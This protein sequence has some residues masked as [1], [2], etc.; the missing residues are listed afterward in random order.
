M[1]KNKKLL[2]F[3]V[4]GLTLFGVQVFAKAG[5]VPSKPAEK[6]DLD[7]N[8]NAKLCNE[9]QLIQLQKLDKIADHLLMEVASEKNLRKFFQDTCANKKNSLTEDKQ[10]KALS[11]MQFKA[12][13]ETTVNMCT[14]YDIMMDSAHFYESSKYSQCN[15]LIS[16]HSGE[17]AQKMKRLDKKD[18]EKICTEAAP[19]Q[20]AF[21]SWTDP[22]VL[23]KIKK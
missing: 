10:F 2:Y 16:Y 20:A 7:I 1:K 15:K 14:H 18:I 23:P 6:L 21:P 13:K 11:N 4:L 3:F 8:L 5:I 22:C 17:I 19:Y 12:W 9:Q